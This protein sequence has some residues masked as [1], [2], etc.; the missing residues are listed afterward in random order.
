M[1]NETGELSSIRP[2]AWWMAMREQHSQNSYALRRQST[3]L[4]GERVFAMSLVNDLEMKS[5][6]IYG[7]LS[8]Q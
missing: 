2:W 7:R 5:S 6:W 4:F 3:T 8:I 1:K